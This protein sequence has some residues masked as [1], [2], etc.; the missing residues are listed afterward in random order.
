M[1][2][3]KAL[4]GL[5][6]L[7]LVI[8]SV[9][10]CVAALPPVPFVM[11]GNEPPAN[12]FLARSE[13]PMSHRN[14]YNQASSPYPGP[15]S[16]EEA[17]PC[18]VES[19]PVP[20]TVAV[21]GVYPNGQQ[22]GWGVTTKEIF[23]M[24]I[25]GNPI[26]YIA[27]QPRLQSKKDAISGAY[28][29]IDNNGVFFVPHGRVLNAYRDS[30][31]GD[32]QS[33][34]ELWRSYELPRTSNFDAEELSD[35]IVG[36]S[37]TYDGRLVLLTEAGWVVSLSRELRDPVSLKLDTTHPISNSL[38]IDETGGIFVVQPDCVVKIHWDPKKLGQDRLAHLWSV[39]FQ[40]STERFP[41]RLGIGSGTTPSL[42]GCGEQDQFVAIGDG[43]QQMHLVLIWRGE[44]PD[45]WE[46]LPNRDRRI[47]AE[48]PVKFGLDGSTQSTT[49]QSLTVRGYE[50]VAVSNQYGSLPRE[51]PR[52]LRRYF[53]SSHMHTIYRSNYPAVAP[54][55]VE[56]FAWNPESRTLESVWAN[57][58][59][60][61]PN[62]IPSMSEATGLL[63]GIGQRDSDWTLEAISWQTGE[64]VFHRRLSRNFRYNSFYSATEIGPHGMIL[65]GMYGGVMRFS[66]QDSQC[67]LH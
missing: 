39:P 7:V 12:P 18:L 13:W 48:V 57:P 11:A 66:D 27:R 21:S 1:H 28:S 61:L 31:Q 56:K 50:I 67:E 38:A 2:R 3:S 44:V 58:S 52:L 5:S 47:A 40:S 22:V 41:G 4:V 26:D 37:L 53:G 55:G 20:I 46:G 60:S 32:P 24:D 36:V 54:H 42:V 10:L 63:Y 23:K 49:E 6:G 30:R 45:D 59:L 35:I 25:A 43:Q 14:S 62:G 64:S 65:N 17:R 33:A 29:L 51:S 19:N 9:A 34:I 15:T 16:P 8:G